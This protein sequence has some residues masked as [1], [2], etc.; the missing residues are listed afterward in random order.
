MHSGDMEHVE[1]GAQ[2]AAKGVPL[3]RDRRVNLY[4]W[5]I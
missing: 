4:D 1:A 2:S 3:E 5:L